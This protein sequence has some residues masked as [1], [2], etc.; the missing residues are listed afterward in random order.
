[1]FYISRRMLLAGIS[2]LAL[3]RACASREDGGPAQSGGRICLG[4]NGLTYWAGYYSLIN[5][6]KQSALVEVLADG[7]RFVSELPPGA[8]ESAWDTYLDT[9]GE[10]VTPLPMGVT[11]LNR[12][13]YA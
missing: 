3:T 6:W 5:V 7:V 4:L 11:H 1:M 9:R 13:F 2:S 12:I 8:R 10:L